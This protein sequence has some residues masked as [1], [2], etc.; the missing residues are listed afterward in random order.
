[1]YITRLNYIAIMFYQRIMVV[2]LENSALELDSIN[3]LIYNYTHRTSKIDL[4]QYAFLPLLFSTPG[5]YSR[6]F[7]CS[8]YCMK[9]RVGPSTLELDFFNSRVY[10]DSL[11]D[12]N[13]DLLSFA[14]LPP[15]MFNPKELFQKLTE[16]QTLHETKSRIPGQYNRVHLKRNIGHHT[17]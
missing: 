1:M 7:R 8:R 13:T 6:N 3:P 11:D 2:A 15:F 5:K 10:F 14:F 9:P 4:L 17:T 12:S 16:V